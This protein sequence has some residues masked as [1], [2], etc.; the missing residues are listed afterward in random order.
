MRQLRLKYPPVAASAARF[1]ADIVATA[2][3]VD[4]VTL[5]YTPDS[6][7][8]VDGMLERF[9]S[10][11]MSSEAIAETL[12]GFGCYVG[13]VMAR[14]AGGRWR[15]A[16]GREV[17]LFGFPMLVELPG[18]EVCNPIGKAFKRVENGTVDS[19]RYFYQVFTGP[20]RGAPG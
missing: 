2:A 11:R 19:L 17:D 8:A 12:F 14:H 16:D 9:R 15:D 4:G 13:E 5:D 3:R 20:L 6:L 7:T 18:G 10:E 1:A